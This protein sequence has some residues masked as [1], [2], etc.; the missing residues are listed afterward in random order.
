LASPIARWVTNAREERSTGREQRGRLQQLG[1]LREDGREHL[2]G[3]IV[4][5]IFTERE[6]V[7]MY[8]RKIAPRHL[9][10]EDTSNTCTCQVRIAECGRSSADRWK[11]IILCEALID[12]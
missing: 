1:V 7:Q 4:I 8:G 6:V 5:P 12:A 10:R 3:S 9:L 2:R 11:E